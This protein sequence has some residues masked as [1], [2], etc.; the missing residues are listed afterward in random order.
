MNQTKY[1]IDK[2]E[3]KK[4]QL[5]EIQTE[6]IIKTFDDIKVAKRWRNFY[7]YGGGFAG[8]TPA[9]MLIDVKAPLLS[10]DDNS[11]TETPKKPRIPR[12]KNRDQVERNGLIL[13]IKDD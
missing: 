12:I 2:T 9:F 7:N 3:D 13:S 11:D 4:F 1:R 8:F 10:T 5:F 6:Q